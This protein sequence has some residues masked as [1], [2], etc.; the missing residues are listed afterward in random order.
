MLGNPDHFSVKQGNTRVS[1]VAERIGETDIGR[2]KLDGGIIFS[3]RFLDIDTAIETLLPLRDVSQ[4]GTVVIDSFV[5]G[6]QAL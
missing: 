6:R 2:A 4:G 3:N 5:T 1:Y